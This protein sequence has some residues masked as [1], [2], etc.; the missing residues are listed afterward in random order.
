MKRMLA[1]LS[2]VLLTSILILGCDGG[3]EVSDGPLN[4]THITEDTVVLN[5][6]VAMDEPLQGVVQAI[7]TRGETSDAV[8]AGADGRF[9]LDIPN[10][11]PFMLR[12]IPHNQGIELFS[13][14]PSAGHVNL[15]P[16]THLAMYVA[17]GTE[18]DLE[19]LFHE[20]DGSQLS[21]EEVQMAAA[22]VSA[23][24]APLLDKQGLDHRTY[25]F[26]RTDFK[27]DGTGMDAVL[28]SVRIHID[29]AAETLSSSIRILD[30]S[31]R[32][33]STFDAAIP[34]VT[35]TAASPATGQKQGDKSQ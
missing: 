11:P 24:L 33:L 23:N 21:P 16:L 26:F 17:V 34:P 30:P 29:A 5:G 25:D 18:V 15:T 12:I 10:Y 4:R 1:V 27:T 20:W 7:N 2:I 6:I 14:A 32:Q 13:F 19:T 3:H 9:T 31:G 35:N 8:I 28:D 22:M